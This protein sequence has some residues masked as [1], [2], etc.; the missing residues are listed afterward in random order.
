MS[1]DT[2]TY[3]FFVE[4]LE[5]GWKQ[6]QLIIRELEQVIVHLMYYIWEKLLYV[7]FYYQMKSA[8][9][10]SVPELSQGSMDII[11]KI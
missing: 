8:I 3:V 1:V 4:S 2:F 6:C 9:V 5:E 11:T 10:K 7:Y